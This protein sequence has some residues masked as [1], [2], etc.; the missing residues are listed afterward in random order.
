M[1]GVTIEFLSR[2]YRQRPDVFSYAAIFLVWQKP[3]Y[4]VDM[5]TSITRTLQPGNEEFG[6]DLLLHR[7][8][9]SPEPPVVG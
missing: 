8:S 5:D 7:S 4:P 9:G 2:D 3:S 1:G 6:A